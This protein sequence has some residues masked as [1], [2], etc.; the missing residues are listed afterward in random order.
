MHRLRDPYNSILVVN[1]MRVL[2]DLLGSA[3]ENHCQLQD[4]LLLS[5]CLDLTDLNPTPRIVLLGSLWHEGPFDHH[6]RA[7]P[8]WIRGSKRG[9]VGAC[10]KSDI[11]Q[12]TSCNSCMLYRYILWWGNLYYDILKLSS[13]WSPILKKTWKLWLGIR[14]VHWWMQTPWYF[15]GWIWGIACGVPEWAYLLARGIKSHEL[16][17]TFRFTLPAG[18]KLLPSMEEIRFRLLELSLMFQETYYGLIPWVLMQWIMSP[19][20]S[21]TLLKPLVR[22]KKQL[23][24]SNVKSQ[25]YIFPKMVINWKH[26]WRI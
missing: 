13:L 12:L 7:K 2:H 11:N 3:M 16:M 24:S 10:A 23:C 6:R 25:R 26:S 20:S 22:K 4:R 21:T 1:L 17:K 19:S 15:F 8:P 5:F 9:C 18:W 14:Y